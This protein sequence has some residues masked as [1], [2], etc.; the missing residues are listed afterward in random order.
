MCEGGT[1]TVMPSMLDTRSSVVSDYGN[2]TTNQA[3]MQSQI[4]SEPLFSWQD[5]QQ[6][7]LSSQAP[8]SSRFD[9]SYA[10][11]Y[12]Q[13]PK[14]A[15]GNVKLNRWGAWAGEP[16][17]GP[18]MPCI[19]SLFA[20]SSSFQSSD[21]LTDS[22]S[23]TSSTPRPNLPLSFRC[24]PRPHWAESPVGSTLHETRTAPRSLSPPSLPYDAADHMGPPFYST[25]PD[26]HAHCQPGM[27]RVY[28]DTE[29]M[30]TVVNYE[31]DG[32][33]TIKN[34]P[35]YAKL[36]YQALMAAPRHRMVL[37][38]IY[39]WIGANTDKAKDPAFKGW[40]NSVRHNL[41]MNGVRLRVTDIFYGQC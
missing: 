5:H 25:A 26:L 7:A 11:S 29:D 22:V 34:E 18:P 16:R 10:T 33:S 41:S 19:P 31:T 6:S 32:E 38:D 4:T 3:H 23:A 30:M 37:R 28:R 21:D 35:P 1:L 17:R 24:N 2:S 20:P 15:H 39:N 27:K 9:M 13:I 12:P 14:E 40:Q 8:Y 36:I